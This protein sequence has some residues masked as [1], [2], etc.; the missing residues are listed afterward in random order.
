MPCGLLLGSLDV[1]QEGEKS[2]DVRSLG[3]SPQVG[4]LVEVKDLILISIHHDNDKIADPSRK[5]CERFF[6]A[7]CLGQAFRCREDGR[8]R[9]QS[10]PLH[11]R[12][13][14]LLPRANFCNVRRERFPDSAIGENRQETGIGWRKL[15]LKYQRRF[16]LRAGG[17]RETE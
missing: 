5:P 14:F 7:I 3:V 17:R 16:H 12:Q 2:V 11:Q 1:I 8:A 4:E 10:F 15:P 13:A 9:R 6:S